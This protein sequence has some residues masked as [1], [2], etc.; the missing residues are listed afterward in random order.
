MCRANNSNHNKQRENP[1]KIQ[2]AFSIVAWD[3]QR[4]RRRDGWR[5]FSVISQVGSHQLVQVAKLFLQQHTVVVSKG[6]SSQI[7]DNIRPSGSD[8]GL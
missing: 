8:S 1:A 6:K 3:C 7:I 2:T 5:Q 4:R